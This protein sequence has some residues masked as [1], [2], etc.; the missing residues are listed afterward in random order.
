MNK[1]TKKNINIMAFFIS[2]I[3]YIILNLLF[4][5]VNLK[6]ETLNQE[7][8][9]E[10]KEVLE[11]S[12]ESK[13]IKDWTIMIPKIN[14]EAE[15]SEGTDQ[16]IMNKYVGHFEE[17]SKAEGNIGLAAHNRGYAVNYFSRLKELKIGDKIYY[18]Y[19]ETEKIYEVNKLK[20]IEDTNWS[21]LEQTDDNK[22]T[23]I[24]C[25]ENEP[26]YRRCIQ[27]IEVKT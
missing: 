19:F 6:T 2:S 23:L 7:K 27:G 24:T 17:T 3:I 1:Y 4:E 21:Y 11:I 12:E 25:V 16:I 18:K 8:I 10:V 26:M 20:I 14:L 15:I 22:I 13:K 5:T 9:P